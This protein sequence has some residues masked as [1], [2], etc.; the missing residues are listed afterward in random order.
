M[1]LYPIAIVPCFLHNSRIPRDFLSHITYPNLPWI[2]AKARLP[3]LP[4]MVPTQ[5]ASSKSHFFP[6][7]LPSADEIHTSYRS[8]SYLLHPRCCQTAIFSPA[9]TTTQAHAHTNDPPWQQNKPSHNVPHN[10]L[11]CHIP[12]P[13][14]YPL[15]K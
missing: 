11:E 14:F 7:F 4:E 9:A 10:I 13:Q 12:L 3:C 8:H 2:Q 1:I 6:L 15:W 5:R